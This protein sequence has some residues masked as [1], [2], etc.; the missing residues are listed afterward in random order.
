MKNTI[1]REMLKAIIHKKFKFLK[2]S[3]L[4]LKGINERG[5]RAQNSSFFSYISINFHPRNLK[6][7]RIFSKKI[8]LFTQVF[9]SYL[10]N[11]SIILKKLLCIKKFYFFY[12]SK[13]I[14]QNEYPELFKLMNRI[15]STY[16]KLLVKRKKI[17]LNIVIKPLIF[18]IIFLKK[19]NEEIVLFS[20]HIRSF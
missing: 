15:L 14:F 4:I 17:I 10:P 8:Q 16:Y 20:S 18:V 3:I 7:N 13:N 6:K 1:L 2:F 11:F 12:L 9:F 19:K 5:P